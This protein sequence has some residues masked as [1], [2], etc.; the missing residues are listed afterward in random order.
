MTDQTRM[1]KYD[2]GYSE[3]FVAVLV[4]YDFCVLNDVAGFGG[5]DC[6]FILDKVLHQCAIDGAWLEAVNVAWGQTK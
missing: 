6:W 2:L 3:C 1:Q 4:E 5:Y